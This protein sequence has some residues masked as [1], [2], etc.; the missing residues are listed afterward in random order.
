M[1]S[2]HFERR[3]DH[4]FNDTYVGVVG[5]LMLSGLG[6]GI[7][8]PLSVTLVSDM[9][10]KDRRFAIKLVPEQ[11]IPAGLMF[12]LPALV[13]EDFGLS[14]MLLALA[15]VIFILS[16]FSAGI[17][18]EGREHVTR[19]SPT[20]SHGHFVVKHGTYLHRE[21]GRDYRVGAA[22]AGRV[23][24]GGDHRVQRLAIQ[25]VGSRGSGISQIAALSVENAVGLEGFV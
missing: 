18:S 22:G 24:I 8:F 1:A 9:S 19:A 23:D 3:N 25:R 4:F 5:G 16:F 10:D 20:G 6:A 14:G 15:G 12:L 11:V 17:P 21:G 7:I 13:I 2:N